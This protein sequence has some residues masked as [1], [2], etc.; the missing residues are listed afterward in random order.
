MRK[1]EPVQLN[2]ES[3]YNGLNAAF[4][5]GNI[6]IYS[7]N[8]SK[9]W[10]S[11][12]FIYGSY[13]EKK[14][15]IDIV[16]LLCME[17]NFIIDYAKTLY[18]PKRPSRIKKL[19]TSYTNENVP[20]FFKYAK[21]KKDNQIAILNDSFVNKLDGMIP[22]PRINCRKL[23][24]DK[25]DYR[26]LMNDPDIECKVR[27]TEH[28]K[29]VKEDTDPLIVRYC[30]LNKIHHFALDDTLKFDNVFSSDVL[31][32]SQLRHDMKYRR[33]YDEIKEEL[34]CFGYTDYEVAD[35]L[36]KFLYGIKKSK[37]KS[38]LWLCYGDI[39]VENLEKYFKPQTKAVQCIDC[40][41]WFEVCI[42]DNRT[43]RCNTCH[44][45]HKRELERLKK[46]RQRDR[47]IN[48]PPIK[49]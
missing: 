12:V 8:I 44:R 35:I 39:I 13:E 24:L 18:K 22:N 21:D 17:N 34:S 26:F 3:I 42:K 5:G 28:G 23:G 30:E 4:T 32:K 1:A 16:K 7:N 10:N 15:A 11:D 25:I 43:C 14:Q 46:K 36:V 2:S 9:I 38:A 6:G 27:F 45:E 49:I 31:S 29:L 48:V 33:I 20:H 47:K 19:I 37:H 40:G 41:E